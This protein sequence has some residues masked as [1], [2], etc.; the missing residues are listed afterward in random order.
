MLHAQIYTEKK[1]RKEL[2]IYATLDYI[3]KELLYVD[4]RRR[5]T[6]KQFHFSVADDSVAVLF[7]YGQ[8]NRVAVALVLPLAQ[9]LKTV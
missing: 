6:Q 4:Y 5:E 1:K 3:Q 2:A 7:V 8:G 9:N